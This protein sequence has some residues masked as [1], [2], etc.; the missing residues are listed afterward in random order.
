MPH[1]IYFAT[2]ILLLLAACTKF[3]D[4]E[5]TERNSFVHFYS[6]ADDYIGSVAELDSDGGYI[7][8]GEIRYDDG[9]TDALIIKTDA[10]GHKMWEKII[11]NGV[12]NAIKPT[13]NGYILLGD[14]IEIN[15]DNQNTAEVS[16]LVNSYARL[17][18]LD[19]QGNILSQHITFSTVTRSEDNKLITLHVDYH[20][21]AL[22]LDASGNIIVLGSFRAPDENESAFVSAFPAADISDSLWYISYQ[23]L[24]HDYINSNAV[25]VTNSSNIVWASK[26]FIQDQNLSR[27]FLSVPH[28]GINSAHINNSVYGESDARNHSVEDMQKSSVGYC[29]IG[30]YSETNG[31]N[32]NMYF[33]RID[34]NLNVLPESARYIDGEELMLNDRILNSQEKT[35]SSSFDEGLALVATNEGYVLAGSMES[36]PTVGNGGKD[37]LLVKV[38][39]FGNLLGKKLLGGSGDE[40]VTSILETPDGGL[41]I[42]GTNTVNGLSSMVLMKTDRDGNLDN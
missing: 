28:V 16:E 13:D 41:L 9:V 3:E 23:S 25:H 38:D 22:A 29:A 42:F 30:T 33:I 40:S 37:I 35:S 1:K 36:T 5:M 8:S 4:A 10:R 32:G 19:K 12:I 20:G 24:Q 7:L 39:P 11:P 21:D 6:S 26:M 18:L 15:T 34:A 17:M 27:G 14:S 31:L 2:A